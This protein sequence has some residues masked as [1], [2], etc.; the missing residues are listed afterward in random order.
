MKN[1]IQ[2]VATL[3]R[4]ATG[5]VKCMFDWLKFSLSGSNEKSD[6][7][8]KLDRDDTVVDGKAMDFFIFMNLMHNDGEN[9]EN[10]K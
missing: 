5:K 3:K 8:N 1:N 4:V 9:T 10:D 6:G 2:K 7:K